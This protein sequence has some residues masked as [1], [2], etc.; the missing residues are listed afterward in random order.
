[1]SLGLSSSW[2]PP[3]SSA[4]ISSRSILGVG[5]GVGGGQ[6]RVI[7]GMRKGPVAPHQCPISHFCRLGK[8]LPL[9][10]SGLGACRSK[11]LE[12]PP[13][14]HGAQDGPGRVGWGRGWA[15]GL[16]LHLPSWP[17]LPAV[18]R[19]WEASLWVS[20]QGVGS[21]GWGSAGQPCVCAT[22]AP[23]GLGSWLR[24]SSQTAPQ[25]S[26]SPAG[27]LSPEGWSTGQGPGGSRVGWGSQVIEWT[28]GGPSGSLVRGEAAREIGVGDNWREGS[29]VS[30]WL[31]AQ[32]SG[33]PYC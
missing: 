7:S 3:C 20:R 22:T 19:V 8:R 10:S 24:T 33:Y 25:S 23:A 29:Q 26:E 17:S 30:K 31:V 4:M 11:R 12:L 14:G 1:M 13:G 16:L 9:I 5:G 15:Q 18:S 32:G 2:H 27:R 21:Q 6:V 28:V